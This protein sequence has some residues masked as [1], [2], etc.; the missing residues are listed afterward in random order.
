MEPTLPL[1]FLDVDGPLNPW[2]AKP[3]RRPEGYTTLRMRPTGWEPPGPALRVWLNPAHGPLLLGLGFR[4]VWATTWKTEAN[5]WIGPVLG[6]PE[7][8]AVDWPQMHHRDPEGVHWKTR[9]LVTSAAGRPFAWVD[10]EI[11]PRDRAWIA[12]HHTGPGLAHRVDPAK[13]LL[14]DDFAAL[15]EWAAEVAGGG[16]P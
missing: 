6:L 5:T 1:L 7:L 4:L 3:H 11:G 9:Y 8:P 14:P 2:R 12:R 16:A 10:D 15:R 13:G